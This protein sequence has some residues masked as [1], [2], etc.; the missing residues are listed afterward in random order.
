[1]EMPSSKQKTKQRESQYN[2]DEYYEFKDVVE[3]KFNKFCYFDFL[4]HI[5]LNNDSDDLNRKEKKKKFNVKEL[6]D[7]IVICEDETK[8][9]EYF[10]KQ[11]ERKIRRKNNRDD[12]SSVQIYRSSVSRRRKSTE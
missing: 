9:K 1:M 6:K 2:E 12:L 8:F 3:S 4:N 5:T 11:S 7:A 10:T